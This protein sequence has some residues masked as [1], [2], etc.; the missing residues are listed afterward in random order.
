MEHDS[1]DETLRALIINGLEQQQIVEFE[2]AQDEED[3]ANALTESV[4]TGLAEIL[5]DE[6][7]DEETPQRAVADLYDACSKWSGQPCE[8]RNVAVEGPAVE[9]GQG[10]YL[11]MEEMDR[12][13]MY[14]VVGYT[15]PDGR[16]YHHRFSAESRVFVL[17]K[18]VVV[19]AHPRMVLGTHG[20][21]EQEASAPATDD[22]IA[23]FYEENEGAHP[24]YDFGDL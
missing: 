22:L 1:T 16:P 11:V 9:L 20:I 5:E 19:I 21:H 15:L 14:A 8:V 24:D 6:P 10:Q 23:E 17:P 4:V 3:L 18:G 12:D 2:D 7:D 13:T